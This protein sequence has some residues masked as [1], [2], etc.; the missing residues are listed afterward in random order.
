M[1][2]R[3]GLSLHKSKR[4]DQKALGYGLYRIVDDPMVIAGE[5]SFSLTLD[6]V[7]RWL[8]SS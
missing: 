6:D 2:K 7:E 4:R 8:M 5:H 1:T 3:R